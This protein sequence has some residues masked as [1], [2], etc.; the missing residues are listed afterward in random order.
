MRFIH[1]IGSLLRFFLLLL[2]LYL[3][4]AIL[5]T[6]FTQKRSY[7][8]DSSE[9]TKTLYL[10]HDFAHTELILPAKELSA[11][12][13]T[14]LAP[15]IPHIT[16]GYIAFS[17]GDALFMQN[18]PRWRDTE[19][20]TALRALF[21]NTPGAI[22]VGHYRAIRQDKSVIP[23]LLS[24]KA[25]QNI[26]KAIYASFKKHEGHPVP[27]QNQKPGSYIYY[28]QAIHPYNLVYTCN[29][30]SADMLRAGA[31]PQPLW[32]PFSFGVVYPF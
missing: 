22:R 13:S 3:F 24:E 17:Y 4:T 18:T 19:T 2:L 20:P 15:Y 21:L 30:W 1:Y 27:I 12:L 23:L 9:K 31:L 26:E 5:F 16:G 7:T 11:E 25:L 6:V 29:Q 32:T 10:Y 14:L 28:F 8:A